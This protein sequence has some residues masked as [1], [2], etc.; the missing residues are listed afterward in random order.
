MWLNTRVIEIWRILS[1]SMPWAMNPYHTFSCALCGACLPALPMMVLIW[2]GTEDTLLSTLRSNF[3]PDLRLLTYYHVWKMMASHYFRE[4][5]CNYGETVSM[6]SHSWKSNFKLRHWKWFS[7]DLRKNSLFFLTVKCHTEQ[8]WISSG[9][10][11]QVIF[12]GFSGKMYNIA[13]ALD[14]LS[15]K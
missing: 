12:L 6:D 2:C 14:K 8:G 7:L 4:I 3:G 5:L 9:C 15:V 10:G 11:K 13:Y 1:G